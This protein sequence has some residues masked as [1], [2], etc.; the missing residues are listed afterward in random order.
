MMRYGMVGV[1]A[2]VVHYS[3]GFSLHTFLDWSP[4]WAHFCGF[5]G[6]FLT[7]YTGHY[8]FSFRDNGRHSNRMPKFFATALIGL[9]LHQTGIYVLSERMQLDYATVAAPLVM[10]SVPLVTF[11]LS[12]LWVFSNPASPQ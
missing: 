12:K 4:F 3:I 10:V 9:T 1:L 5:F 7:A 2:T 8:H 6:G 11:L